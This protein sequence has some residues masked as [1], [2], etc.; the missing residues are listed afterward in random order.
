MKF[1]FKMAVKSIL[2]NRKKFIHNIAGVSVGVLLLVLVASLSSSF[3]DVL[4]SQMK[5]SDDKVMTIAVGN[6][7]NTLTY[8]CLPV[9]DNSTLDIVNSEKNIAKSTGIKDIDVTSVFYKDSEGKNKIILSSKI[10]SSNQVFLDLYRVKIKQGTFCA[11]KDEVIIGADIAKTYGIKFGDSIDI[12]YLGKKYTFKVSGILDKM[13]RMGYSNITDVINNII[14]ISEESPIVKDSKYSAILAEVT[15]VNLLEQESKRIT[16]L[17]NTKSNM[18]QELIDTGLDAIVVNNLAILEM[19]NGY[20]KY[21]NMFIILLFLITSLIVVLNF[22]NIMTIT[23]MGRKREIGIMKIIGGSNSQISKFYSVECM[24]TGI[25]GSVIGLILGI[26]IYLLIIFA[27]N[28]T[29]RL[30]LIVCLFALLVGIISPT[31]A[32]VLTQRKIKKQTISDIFNE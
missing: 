30:S 16:D 31:L 23:I 12:E 6:R 11:N 17:L 1:Y 14:L 20:F 2:S 10:D 8:W 21:V 3:K 18:S 13:R 28:W 19:I 4:Y 5:I 22:S 32:G 29:F 9:Y 26:L 7:K 27:L 25:V 24:F 15:D